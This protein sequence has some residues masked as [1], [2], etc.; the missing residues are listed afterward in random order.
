LSGIIPIREQKC[1]R[2][3]KRAEAFRSK[4]ESVGDD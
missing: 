2:I 1:K 4:L 3:P